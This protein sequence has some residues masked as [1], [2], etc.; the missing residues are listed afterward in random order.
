MEDE[1]LRIR[2]IRGDVSV[3]FDKERF[4]PAEVILLMSDMRKDL[5]RLLQ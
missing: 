2:T 4:R 3:M 1:G 5:Q